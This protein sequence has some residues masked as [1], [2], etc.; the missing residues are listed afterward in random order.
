MHLVSYAPHG[1]SK[2]LEHA[3]VELVNEA[4]CATIL[5]TFNFLNMQSW[6]DIHIPIE[7]NRGDIYHYEVFRNSHPGT[8]VGTASTR[9]ACSQYSIV[10]AAA[11][12]A[13]NGGR[14][15]TIAAGRYFNVPHCNVLFTQSGHDV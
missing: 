6:Y 15:T 5:N 8:V 10:Y 13:F 3:I 14:N 11:Y 4:I 12:D 9:R 2:S 1:N 7:V